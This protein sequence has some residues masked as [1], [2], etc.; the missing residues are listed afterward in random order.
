MINIFNIILIIIY[1]LLELFELILIVRCV[2]SF[3]MQGG[4]NS[5]YAFLCRITEPV[6]APIR[7]V[8]NRTPLGNMMLDF[9]PVVA[10]LLIGVVE[11]CLV[12]ISRIF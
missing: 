10:V 3:F 11:R 8:L 6:L 5:F 4:Y 7:N 2:L 1:R 9:S 12:L